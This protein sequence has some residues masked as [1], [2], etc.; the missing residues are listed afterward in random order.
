MT[1][2]V[3]EHPGGN[4]ILRN[5]G[6]DV[7]TDFNK[8]AAHNIVKRMIQGILSKNYVGDVT[9]TDTST[10]KTDVK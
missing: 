8:V 10:T 7:T 3:Q 1:S 4:A 2:Y 6:S 9:E 5:A